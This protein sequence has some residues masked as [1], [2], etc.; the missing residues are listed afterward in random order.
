MRA[1]IVIFALL[2]V[3]LS[4]FGLAMIAAGLYLAGES[5]FR[6]TPKSSEHVEK[7]I[8]ALFAVVGVAIIVLYVWTAMNQSQRLMRFTL[9]GQALFILLN[10]ISPIVVE[11]K[12]L[13]IWRCL[14]SVYSERRPG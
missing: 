1:A 2:V 5:E 9:I 8:Y 3:T 14:G 6:A 10:I 12:R 4:S 13:R 7:F 11:L